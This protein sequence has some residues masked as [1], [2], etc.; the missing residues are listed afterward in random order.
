MDVRLARFLVAS[1]ALTAAHQVADHWI[2][3]DRQA[4]TK[5]G[6]GRRAKLACAGHVAT[7]TA[8]Q[9]L[10]LVGAAKWLGVP[11]SARWAAA[12]L[13]V[14]AGTHYFADRRGPLRRLAEATG[15]APFYATNTGGLNGAYL[16]D[17]SFHSGWNFVAALIIAGRD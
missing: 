6:R 5:G 2:Q 13:V 7:Y 1:A 10:A 15:H 4:C 11:L 8:T 3:T 12:G 16:L 14:S 9:A 17:Q